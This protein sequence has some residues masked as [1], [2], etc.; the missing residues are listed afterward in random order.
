MATPAVTYPTSFLRAIDIGLQ[1]LLFTKFQDIL[2]LETIN[3]GVL[4]RPKETAFDMW[5]K[6][7]ATLN[8]SS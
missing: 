6:R 3:H 7:R 8:L 2:G 4:R 1:G 5:R